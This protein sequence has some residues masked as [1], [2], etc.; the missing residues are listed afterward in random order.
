MGNWEYKILEFT[1]NLGALQGF[2][3][4]ESNEAWELGA[5]LPIQALSVDD[6]AINAVVAPAPQGAYVVF[7]RQIPMMQSATATMAR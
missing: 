5:L 3:S 2:L 4:Q 1:G 6:Q 7:K